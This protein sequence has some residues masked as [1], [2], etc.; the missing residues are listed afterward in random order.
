M[1]SEFITVW[2]AQPLAGSYLTFR[3]LNFRSRRTVCRG[4][5]NKNS[6]EIKANRR[7]A[8]EMSIR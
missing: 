1:F 6:G 2:N 7:V 4:Q 3:I 8:N 5:A